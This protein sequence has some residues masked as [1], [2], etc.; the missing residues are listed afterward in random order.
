[1]VKLNFTT[2]LPL[3]FSAH[4]EKSLQAQNPGSPSDAC[5]YSGPCAIGVGVPE[6]QRARL[7]RDDAPEITFLIRDGKVKIGEEELI[8]E[9]GKLQGLHDKWRHDA[10]KQHKG[11][12]A[13]SEQKFL[14]YLIELSKKYNVE[15]PDG[16]LTD[17]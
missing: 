4:S 5:L 17:S 1:M 14:S 9:Y 2:L 3:I 13:L 16:Y 10:S 15:I 12:E 6:T 7:D 11:L 8:S